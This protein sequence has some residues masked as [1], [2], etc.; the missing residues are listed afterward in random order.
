MQKALAHISRAEE[1]LGFGQHSRKKLTC[2]R[3]R[4]INE[5][6]SSVSPERTCLEDLT[7]NA[8]CKSEGKCIRKSTQEKLEKQNHTEQL[9]N[10]SSQK[11]QDHTEISSHQEFEEPP[12]EAEVKQKK[13]DSLRAMDALVDVYDSKYVFPD[14]AIEVVTE[15]YDKLMKN[16]VVYYDK[17]D[18]TEDVKQLAMQ[19]EPVNIKMS[20]AGFNVSKLQ[21]YFG[22]TQSYYQEFWEKR[23]KLAPNI[24]VYTPAFVKHKGKHFPFYAHV[25]VLNSVGYAL[26]STDQPD[27]QYFFGQKH[28]NRTKQ[29]IDAYV[30]VFQKMVACAKALDLQ[31]IAVSLVGACNLAVL[32]E[33]NRQQEGID[34][35]QKDVWVPAFQQVKDANPSIFWA[36]IGASQSKAFELISQNYENVLDLGNFPDAVNHEWVNLELRRWKKQTLFVNPLNPHSVPGNGNKQN[37]DIDGHIGCLTTIALNG[38]SM[39]NPFIQYKAISEVDGNS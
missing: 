26:D 23:K 1:L 21:K 4:M 3:N 28:Q 30:K 32:Y 19:R 35:F 37:T 33:G 38:T 7:Y 20:R 2:G 27:W 34:A 29:L 18:N 31:Q 16:A 14:W 24:A 36:F 9:M 8:L 11:A 12:T 5:Y 15:K 13:D 39:T 17:S 25:H 10:T 22:F 6:T